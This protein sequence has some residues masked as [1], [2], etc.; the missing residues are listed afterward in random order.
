MSQPMRAFTA[1]NGLN[2][3]IYEIDRT[4]WRLAHCWNLK[5]HNFPYFLST[6]LDLT[7]SGL[8]QLKIAK[9]ILYLP[10]GTTWLW[11]DFVFELRVVNNIELSFFLAL[12][13]PKGNSSRR[14][15]RR[16]EK[17]NLAPIDIVASLQLKMGSG[18]QQHSHLH[19]ILVFMKL[20]PENQNNREVLSVTSR[21][22]HN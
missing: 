20:P 22:K 7:F 17:R 9:I 8:L 19:V 10:D 11:A 12:W 2:C 16:W 1:C 5:V 3:T 15:R 18:V 21:T 4:T 6:C 13:P 14:S